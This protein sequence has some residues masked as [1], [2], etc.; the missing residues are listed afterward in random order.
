LA[1]AVSAGSALAGLAAANITVYDNFGPG[2]G[3]FDYNWGLGW[4]VAGEDVPNQFGVEQA[5]LFTP[6]DSGPVSDIWVAMWY[7]PLDAGVDEVVVRL[8]ENTNGSYPLLADVM[9]E[10]TISDFEDW[11][12]WSPP[13]HLVGDGGSILEAGTSYWLWA[14]PAND[15]TWTGWCMNLDPGLTLPHTL[16]REGEDWLAVGNETA[17][18]FRVDVVPMPGSVGLLGVA[19]LLATRRR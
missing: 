4:T 13:H 5:F 11:S 14:A 16:R 3:G 1:A 2:N 6:S 12:A 17:S 7:V 10:W 18:A 19:G 9:Q 8:A 15:T